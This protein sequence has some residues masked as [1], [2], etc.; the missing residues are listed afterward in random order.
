MSANLSRSWFK[1]KNNFSLILYHFF[2]GNIWYHHIHIAGL[3]HNLVPRCGPHIWEKEICRPEFT[4]EH[5]FIFAIDYFLICR[6]VQMSVSSNSMLVKCSINL[7]I[8]LKVTS[9]NWTSV[10]NIGTA[11]YH[12]LSHLIRPRS[13]LHHHTPMSDRYIWN[14]YRRIDDP[15]K[16]H[17]LKDRTTICITFVKH[18]LARCF[19]TWQFN[20]SFTLQH[21]YGLS[22][23]AI[24]VCMINTVSGVQLHVQ[25]LVRWLEG[26]G[27][28]NKSDKS[29]RCLV[30]FS[31]LLLFEH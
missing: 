10:L 6:N 22:Y 18:Y 28:S 17:M 24:I 25:A 14:Y 21:V 8:F 9:E 23:I 7:R 30:L 15:C 4:F 29:P 27:G 2:Y 5:N 19:S 20:F 16:T 11:T 13:R 12:I 31:D 1:S 3:L 26:V